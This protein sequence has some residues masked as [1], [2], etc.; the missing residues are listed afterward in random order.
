[1]RRLLA[2][3]TLLLFAVTACSTGSTSNVD[4]I[5]DEDLISIGSTLYKGNCASCH[6]DDLRGTDQGPSHLS[7]VYEPG[8]HGD[9][10][11]QRAVLLGSQQHHWG[12]GSMPSIEGLDREQVA[13]IVAFVR[14]R[15]ETEGFEPYPP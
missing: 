9:E 13:A 2:V 8:H 1:M 14:D 6:G 15:Q 7:E 10:A 4:P 5:P 12:F 11:F 3:S